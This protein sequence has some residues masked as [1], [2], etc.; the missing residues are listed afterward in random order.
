MPRRF[1]GLLLAVRLLPQ[2]GPS[3]VGQVVDALGWRFITRLLLPLTSP[4][5]TPAPAPAAPSSAAQQQAEL[6]C[7]LGLSIT[8]AACRLPDQASSRQVQ[9]LVPALARVVVQGGVGPALGLRAPL[10]KPPAPPAAQARGPAGGQEGVEGDAG[11]DGG[12]AAAAA[13][14]DLASVAEALECLVAVAQAGG[15]GGR[16]ALLAGGALEAGVT[17][18]EWV[19]AWAGTTSA[20]SGAGAGSSGGN[21]QG[22]EANCWRGPVLAARLISLLVTGQ[23][24]QG[25][26]FDAGERCCR[27]LMAA[28]LPSS[29]CERLGRCTVGWLVGATTSTAGHVRVPGITCC[30]GHEKVL[31]ACVPAL[32]HA[33]GLHTLLALD[34]QR[35]QATQQ[36]PQ[37]A[38]VPAPAP[39]PAG[40]RGEDA[41]M[42]QLECLHTLLLLLARP[43]PHTAGRL[44]RHLRGTAYAA[45]PAPAARGGRAAGPAQQP[46]IQQG[47]AAAVHRGLGWMLRSRTG[48]EPRMRHGGTPCAAPVRMQCQGCRWRRHVPARVQRCSRPCPCPTCAQRLSRGTRPSSSQLQW[49]TC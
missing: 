13:A 44:R 1:V 8:S 26:S 12:E 48:T 10:L 40:A 19:R 21:G 24:A 34:Q 15:D 31:E 29:K 42:L 47:W 5:A 18:L 20:H 16:E 43:L 49:W 23:P 28:A 22:G 41:A 37:P 30:A 38:G 33:L 2:G 17:Q 36:Q 32:G 45:H 39:A 14:S 4:A 35:Q 46:S 11:A 27:A 7:S 6:T 9:D 3:A 25:A